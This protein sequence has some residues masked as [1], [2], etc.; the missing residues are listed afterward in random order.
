MRIVY[1]STNVA[2]LYVLRD[3]LAQADIQAH[4]Q[5]EFLRGG[6]GELPADTPVSL[7]VP[8]AQADTARAIVLDWERSRPDDDDAE[9]AAE[10]AAAAPMGPA[11]RDGSVFQIVGAFVLGALCSGAIVW[12]IYNHPSEGLTRDFDGDG[13][14][15]ERVILAGDRI[16]RVEY[17]RNHDGK[18]DR[19]VY[20]G[21]NH[22]P[23]RAEFDHD[24]DGRLEGRE[25]YDENEP[26][27]WSQ[28]RDGDGVVEL[29]AVY[30]HGVVAKEET[31][32]KHAQITRTI[33]F[34]GGV[35]VSGEF[36]ANGDGVL[37]TARTYDANGEIV[38]SRP[39]AAAKGG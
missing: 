37:D 35:P 29:R 12:A 9:D 15:D 20:Y 7:A 26:V 30:V 13:N 17:D 39:L 38:A 24:F 36:D 18:V 14:A 16:E 23:D 21:R 8:D 10:G 4:V 6:I 22:L 32:N 2:D 27:E 34:R 19:I 5:G 31:F 28:D 33:E 25:R 3:L 11:N 1:Q